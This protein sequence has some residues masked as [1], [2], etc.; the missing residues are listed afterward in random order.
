MI[1]SGLRVVLALHCYLGEA[2]DQNPSQHQ[3]SSH[4]LCFTIISGGEMYESPSSCC[5]IFINKTQT[6]YSENPQT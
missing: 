6:L 5:F 1:W 4:C 2:D 3:C